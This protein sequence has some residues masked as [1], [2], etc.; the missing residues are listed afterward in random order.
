MIQEGVLM[1]LSTLSSSLAQRDAE[2]KIKK[3]KYQQ[4]DGHFSKNKKL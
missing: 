1:S 2:N 3:Q 4:I